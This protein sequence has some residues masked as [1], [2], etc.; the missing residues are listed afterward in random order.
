MYCDRCGEDIETSYHVFLTCP[1]L[2]TASWLLSLLRI[3][4]FIDSSAVN[5]WVTNFY[6]NNGKEKTELLAM[7]LWADYG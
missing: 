1:P 5:R 4:E 2:I 6:E 7:L 3:D